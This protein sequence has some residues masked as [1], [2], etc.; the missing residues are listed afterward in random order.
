MAA[1]PMPRSAAVPVA[2]AQEVSVVRQQETPLAARAAQVPVLLLAV[3]ASLTPQVDQ[4][5]PQQ[6]AMAQL[7]LQTV[8]TEALEVEGLR[9]AWVEMGEMALSSSPTPQVTSAARAQAAPLLPL[10][11]TVSTRSPQAA[12]SLLSRKPPLPQHKAPS[13][14]QAKQLL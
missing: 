14:F 8:A 7:A 13:P 1:V 3:L 12:H 10:A 4:V 6:L 11:A 2:V 5:E 9:A